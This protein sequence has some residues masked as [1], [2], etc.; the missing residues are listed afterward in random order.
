VDQ[1]QQIGAQG[2]SVFLQEA[3]GVIE[4]DASKVAQAE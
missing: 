2:V 4:D 3:S 1:L